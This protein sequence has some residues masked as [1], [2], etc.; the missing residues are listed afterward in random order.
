MARMQRGCDLCGQRGPL[1]KGVCRRCLSS[2]LEKLPAP[3]VPAADLMRDAEE[4][5]RARGPAIGRTRRHC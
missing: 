1:I 5:R 3:G 2:T 4:S